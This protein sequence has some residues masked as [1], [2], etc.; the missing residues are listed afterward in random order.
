M[1]QFLIYFGATMKIGKILILCTITGL[2]AVPTI[3]AEKIYLQN[4]K[5]KAILD[6]MEKITLLEFLY[7]SVLLHKNLFL[8]MVNPAHKPGANNN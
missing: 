8:L 4:P 6:S 5:S 3:S 1:Y 2:I 7:L